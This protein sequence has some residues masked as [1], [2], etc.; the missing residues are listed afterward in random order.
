MQE[1]P[2]EL[3]A[4]ISQKTF[5]ASVF[6]DR[7]L[8]ALFRYLAQMSNARQILWCYFLWYLVTLSYYF[9]PSPNIWLTSSGL[10]IIVGF[11]LYLNA[12][13][14]AK[15]PIKLEF[16]QKARFYLTPFCVSSF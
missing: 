4:E 2:S 13:S 7:T 1:Q 16:W 5:V 14:S 15:V 6:V 12:K 3:A 11:A 9:D 10:S 8:G